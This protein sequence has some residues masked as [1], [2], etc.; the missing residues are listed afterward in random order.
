MCTPR[1]KPAMTAGRWAGGHHVRHDHRPVHSNP[2]G[3]NNGFFESAGSDHLGGAHFGMAD[4]SVHFL[5]E[6]IDSANNNTSVYPLLGSMADGQPAS[7]PPN[8]SVCAH[9]RYL[10]PALLAFAPGC[11]SGQPSLGKVRGQVTMDGRPLA[12][13]TVSF[14]PLAGGRQSSGVTDEQGQYELVYLRDIKGAVVGKHRVRIGS[15]SRTAPPKQRLP[16]R[17][18]RKTTLE[19]EVKRGKTSLTLH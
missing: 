19:A 10:V 11:G 17:Y 14:E 7:L 18:N 8:R 5:R 6:T 3:I 15:D 1:T 16:S 12:G 4:G 2:G 13:V 9:L